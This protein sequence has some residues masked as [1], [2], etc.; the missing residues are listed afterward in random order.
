MVLCL[1]FWIKFIVDTDSFL[2]L[3][4]AWLNHQRQGTLRLVLSAGEQET[5]K[6]A[7]GLVINPLLIFDPEDK[8]RRLE[9]IG[10]ILQS[11]P[12][13]KHSPYDTVLLPLYRVLIAAASD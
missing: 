3:K 2:R 10:V 4:F 6:K 11:E 1:S 9:G 7:H 8:I 12:H 13:R 5:P